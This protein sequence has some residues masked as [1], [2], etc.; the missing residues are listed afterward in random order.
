MTIVAGNDLETLSAGQD[1][2][3]LHEQ[4]QR[5]TIH[6]FGVNVKQH[7]RTICDVQCNWHSHSNIAWQVFEEH[8]KVELAL[9]NLWSQIIVANQT[10][11]P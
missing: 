9:Q 4:I 2:C 11:L 10:I 8:G 7:C 5:T 1:V 3:K 6:L